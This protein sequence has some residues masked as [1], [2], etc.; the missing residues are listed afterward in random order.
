M[1]VPSIVERATAIGV[2]ASIVRLRGI[3]DSFDAT[4]WSSTHRDDGCLGDAE[5]HRPR[6]VLTP[7]GRATHEPRQLRLF[8]AVSERRAWE[9]DLEGSAVPGVSTHVRTGNVR[10][11]R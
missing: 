7:G 2:R 1:G 8:F 6:I 4:D 5:L 11:R 3:G 10:R 9:C